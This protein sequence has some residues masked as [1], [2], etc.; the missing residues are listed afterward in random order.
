MIV[1]FYFYLAG[2]TLFANAEDATEEDEIEVDAETPTD[3]P[4][5]TPKEEDS[6]E[7]EEDDKKKQG[8]PDIELTM[9]FTKPVGDGSGNSHI[10]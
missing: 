1:I 6:T 7:D 10:F 3:T 9:L 2:R 5:E 4:A 8:S